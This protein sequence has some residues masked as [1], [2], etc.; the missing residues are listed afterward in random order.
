MSNKK[1]END[2]NWNWQNKIINWCFLPQSHTNNVHVLKKSLQLHYSGL[3]ISIRQRFRRTWASAIM[4]SLLLLAAA[5]A[6]A[7]MIGIVDVGAIKWL[8]RSYWQWQY[9]DLI[10]CVP[11]G[12][13]D[14]LLLSA[15]PESVEETTMGCNRMRWDGG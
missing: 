11:G 13:V 10:K 14:L 1:W 6:S 8:W 4:L 7:D 9:E 5:A 2:E 12:V 3:A 15:L